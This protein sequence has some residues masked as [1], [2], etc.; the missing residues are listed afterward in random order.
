MLDAIRRQYKRRQ[1]AEQRLCYDD[2]PTFPL[3][4]ANKFFPTHRV[5]NYGITFIS[6]YTK[7]LLL[8]AICGKKRGN[9][10]YDA[11]CPV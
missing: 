6:V 7:T 4:I 10:T 9:S 2:N 11:K 8:A 1:D 5:L 3:T